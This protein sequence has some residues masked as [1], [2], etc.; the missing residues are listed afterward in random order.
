[1][2]TYVGV[3]GWICTLWVVTLPV[4][5]DAQ[6]TSTCEKFNLTFEL[7]DL[8]ALLVALLTYCT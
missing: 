3:K 4:I 5:A 7:F 8:T 1:M 2:G 6:S